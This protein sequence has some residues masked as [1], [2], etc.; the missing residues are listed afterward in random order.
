[1]GTS[2]NFYVYLGIKIDFDDELHE[3]YDPIY[4]DPNTPNII[5]ECICGEYMILGEIL[6]NS[7]DYRFYFEDYKH[8]Q[9]VNPKDLISIE[10]EYKENFIKTFPKFSHY[11]EKDFELQMIM[12]F[13]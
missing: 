6:F 5:P 3:E 4:G 2:T 8:D 9:R 11:M 10:K 1:M 13:S 7:G 12:H